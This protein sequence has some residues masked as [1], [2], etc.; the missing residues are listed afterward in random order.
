M[1]LPLYLTDPGALATAV[2][3]SRVDVTG[4][5]ARHAVTV[6]RTAVG[7]QVQ[8][9]AL[10]DRID[11]WQAFQRLP[12]AAIGLDDPH[13]AG[14]FGDEHAS[15][16]D[17][18]HGPGVLQVTGDHL[19]HR[20]GGA[21]RNAGDRADGQQHTGQNRQRK[22]A[23]GSEAHANLLKRV[24]WQDLIGGHRFPCRRAIGDTWGITPTRRPIR[25]RA[26]SAGCGRSGAW[27]LARRARTP[28]A[29][30]PRDSRSPGSRH[31]QTGEAR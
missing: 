19:H 22:G 8:Q 31:G 18:S 9:S 14:P 28:G 4:P 29:P 12:D 21:R 30:G 3:G 25:H 7:D 10:P 27:A 13:A 2:V 24:R 23:T 15:L 5:E 1:T 17:E 20:L 11:G 26:R 6:R 16:T